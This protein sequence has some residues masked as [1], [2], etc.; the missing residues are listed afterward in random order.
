MRRADLCSLCS[1]PVGGRGIRAFW[2]AA[3]HH[4]AAHHWALSDRVRIAA[5]QQLRPWLLMDFL[6]MRGPSAPPEAS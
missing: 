6:R 2:L 3:G 4:F 5:A 1:A